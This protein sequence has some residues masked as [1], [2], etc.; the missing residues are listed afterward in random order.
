MW[1]V[2]RSWMIRCCLVVEHAASTDMVNSSLRMWQQTVQL[3]EIALQ[4]P[5]GNEQ[6]NPNNEML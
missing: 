5:P 2:N 1:T 4:K 3:Q 6:G